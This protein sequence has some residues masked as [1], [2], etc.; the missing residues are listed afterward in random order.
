M[1]MIF[2]LIYGLI[3]GFREIVKKESL[4]KNTVMEVLFFY[5]LFAFLIVCPDIKN[6]FGV[7]YE[8][9][10]IIMIKALAVFSA[11]IFSFHAIKKLPISLY[12]ILDLSRVVFATL[13]AIAVLH[14]S[15]TL[16]TT[17]G[18]ILVSIGLLLLKF[19]TK[20]SKKEKAPV[21]LVLFALASCM[22]NAFSGLLDKILMKDLTSTQLQ[23]WYMLFMVIYY[24]LYILVTRTKIN[25][26][27]SVK[28]PWIWLLA[29]LF[30]IAD[31]S[32]FMANA[33]PASKIT[34]MT[35]IKQ[36]SC[37]VTI[38]AGKFL[39]HEKNILHKS[40]CAAIVLAGIVISVL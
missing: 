18:L 17:A 15:P 29:V 35:L 28:N 9:M 32:L 4:K 3:K 37:L 5:T 25:M 14:E 36:S 24:L 38:F 39:Y 2:V 10:W 13:L 40:I 21:K 6:A 31:R 1:W 16:S 19:P 34:V 12:G 26:K 27:T 20:E 22:L 33:D 11:W 30:V 8:K 7:P 23:F